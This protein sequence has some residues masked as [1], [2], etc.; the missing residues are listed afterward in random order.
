VAQQ[1]CLV[2]NP[3]AL[4]PRYFPT[5][6]QDVVTHSLPFQTRKQFGIPTLDLVIA[7]RDAQKLLLPHEYQ[8][9]LAPR[10]PGV[11]PKILHAA[12][13]RYS[14]HWHLNNEGYSSATLSHF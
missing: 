14:Q 13:Q 1:F 6:L 3:N 8:Q 2:K 12:M 4:V 9:L 10:D 11:K 7:N 5:P